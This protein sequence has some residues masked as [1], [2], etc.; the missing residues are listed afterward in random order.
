MDRLTVLTHGATN[1]KEISFSGRGVTERAEE[2]CNSEGGRG[3]MLQRLKKSFVRV[4][5][6]HMYYFSCL[7]PD[8]TSR[9]WNSSRTTTTGIQIN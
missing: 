2:L 3:E 1:T 9:E 6:L 5:S 7:S 4:M 8:G